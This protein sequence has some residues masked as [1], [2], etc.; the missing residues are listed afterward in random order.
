MIDYSGYMYP[1]F[2]SRV[3][4][5]NY[6]EIVFNGNDINGT[7]K[8]SGKKV[9]GNL[10]LGDMFTYKYTIGITIEG[11]INSRNDIEGTYTGNGI[12]GTFKIE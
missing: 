1:I 4:K 12:S 11:T 8:K 6:K 2:E 5:S 10:T 3:I 9:S 7:L